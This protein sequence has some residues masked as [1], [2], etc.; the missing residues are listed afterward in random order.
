ME[1]KYYTPTREEFHIGFEYQYLPNSMVYEEDGIWE[2]KGEGLDFL[3]K[4]NKVQ[5]KY[6]DREDIE[7]L[8]FEKSV[9]MIK[10]FIHPTEFIGIQLW[11]GEVV[12]YTKFGMFDREEQVFKGTIKN[13]SELKKV[14]KMIGYDEV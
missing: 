1:A 12:I 6:L 11:Q 4:H 10:S 13:K 5:V 14:L 9:V 8:G 7:S 3:F 2:G